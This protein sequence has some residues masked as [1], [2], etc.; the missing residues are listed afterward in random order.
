ML[1]FYAPCPAH[2]HST[3]LKQISNKHKQSLPHRLIPLPYA[4][5]RTKVMV[6]AIFFRPQPILLQDDH[7]KADMP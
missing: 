7:S 6:L 3:S 5:T 2:C 1:A 4:V